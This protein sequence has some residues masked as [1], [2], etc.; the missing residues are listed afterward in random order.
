MECVGNN[1]F[2]VLLHNS[3]LVVAER[4]TYGNVESCMM[5]DLIYG[6]VSSVEGS[7]EDTNQ[8]RYWFHGDGDGDL[9][10]RTTEKYLR[11]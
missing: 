3:L 4:D 5:H 8:V 9:N 7:T 1:L 11:N 6:L 10:G 2:N